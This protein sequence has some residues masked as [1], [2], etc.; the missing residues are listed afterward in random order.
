MRGSYRL[1]RF[2]DIEVRVHLTFWLLLAWIGFSAFSERGIGALISS[3]LFVVMLFSF[4]VLHEYGHALT[5]RRFGIRTRGITLY[6]IGGVAMLESMPKDPKQQILVALA[7]PAVN[8][9]L[10]GVVFGVASAVGVN[11]FDAEI[12]PTRG[13]GALL[14]TLF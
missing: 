8:L 14:G 5:A 1:G 13:L 2:F 11:L 12:D 6:P 7:G 9:V 10:A 3:V 4:V